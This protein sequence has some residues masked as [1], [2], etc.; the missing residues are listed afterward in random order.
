MFGPEDITR[1][2]A[3]WRYVAVRVNTR[4][5][6]VR[7]PAYAKGNV[8]VQVLCRSMHVCSFPSGVAFYHGSDCYWLPW[9][10]ILTLDEYIPAAARDKRI[11]RPIRRKLR[12]IRGGL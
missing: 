6:H 12:L 1:A 3:T 7:L 9:L 4:V 2:L 5:P 10:A 11:T 8:T